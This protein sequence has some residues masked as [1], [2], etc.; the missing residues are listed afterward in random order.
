MTYNVFSGTLNPTQSISLMLPVFDN[1]EHSTLFK[2]ADTRYQ[3]RWQQ[4]TQIVIRNDDTCR[5]Q[6]NVISLQ[7]R[8]FDT[9]MRFA[10]EYVLSLNASVLLPLCIVA[11][12]TLFCSR[13][14]GLWPVKIDFELRPFGHNRV[15]Q[16][17]EINLKTGS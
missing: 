3:R 17:T 14:K 9:Q 8:S 16:L 11:W 13:R 7:Q 5:H 12:Y 4:F 6:L 10:S 2:A 1:S 15:N